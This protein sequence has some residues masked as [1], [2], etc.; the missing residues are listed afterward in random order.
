[1]EIRRSYDRLISIMGF[2][3]PVRRYL[4]IESG[5]RLVLASFSMCFSYPGITTPSLFFSHNPVLHPLPSQERCQI[6]TPEKPFIIAFW[7]QQNSWCR[8]TCILIRWNSR[9][10]YING[11]WYFGLCDLEIWWMTSRNNRAPLL[12]LCKLYALLCSH[13]WNQA[14]VTVQKYPN[15][16]TLFLLTPV[17]LTFHLWPCL[18]PGTTLLSMVITPEN[19]MMI[20]WKEH[21]KKSVRKHFL[22]SVV[23]FSALMCS[24][25]YWKHS[26]QS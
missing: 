23:L 20:W 18:F 1:M 25:R 9:N 24:L 7:P 10:M 2:P 21:C 12:C 22:Q 6:L 11:S 19:C 13:L 16:Y 3:I 8:C 4:Y 15:W 5:P 17:T 14:G 26:N